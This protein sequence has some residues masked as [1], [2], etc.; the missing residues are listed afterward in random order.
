MPDPL[1]LL[2]SDWTLSLSVFKVLDLV[3][4]ALG[5]GSET[6]ERAGAFTLSTFWVFLV[7]LVLGV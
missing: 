6:L 7:G 2:D 1:G 3:S 5:L 4:I